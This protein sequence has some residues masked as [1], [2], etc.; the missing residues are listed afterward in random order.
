MN[1]PQRTTRF[2]VDE[3]LALERASEERHIYVDGEIFDM[4]GESGEHGDVSFNIVGTLFGQLKDTPC[5]GRTKDTKVRSGIGPMSGRS[6]KGMFSYPDVLVI[7]G[8]PEYHDTWKD[9]VLNPTAIFEVLS[10][11]T[12]VFDRGEKF[13]RYQA[14]N[15]TLRDYFLVS[16]NTP[17]VEHYTR[18]GDG[19]WSYCTQIGLD[20]TIEIPSIKCT[21]KL[22]DIYDRV[23]FAKSDDQE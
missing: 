11:G 8:E 13:Q 23:V 21:L 22:S 5:R 1:M 18:Q 12:E 16:Q 14:W 20:A 10:P 2:T 15:P 9:V 6:T 3:Y 4:A 19:Q 17:R 7:C